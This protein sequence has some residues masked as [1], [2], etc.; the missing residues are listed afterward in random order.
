MP[1]LLRGALAVFDAGFG[2]A[3]YV[4]GKFANAG[5][6]AA[7][8][9]ASWNGS[10][11]ADLGGGVSGTV[12]ALAVFDDGS[13]PELYVG[14]SF[15]A[16][17]GV[18]ANNIAKWNGSTWST[19][20][21]GT[22]GPVYT[23]RVFDDGSGD[24]LYVGGSFSSRI[25]RWDHSGWSTVGGGW[26]PSLASPQS[27]AVFDDGYGTALYVGTNPGC[28]CDA[29]IVKWNGVTWSYVT[30]LV[31]IHSI[32]ALAV[33]EASSESAPGLFVGVQS[34][35]AYH[36]GW[37]SSGI[38]EW[39]GCGHPGVPFCFGDGTSG[40]CPCGNFGAPGHGCEN[41]ASTGGA[42]L[43]SAGW[44][45]L[46]F[47]SLQLT[48]HGERSTAFSI[49]LQ[50]TSSIAPVVYGD[51]LRCISVPLTRLFVKHAVGGIASAPEPGDP[52]ISSRSAA[53]GDPLFVGAT[54]LYQVF[55]R[56]PSTAFCPNP[57]GN[58][59]NISNARRIQWMP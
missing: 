22:D 18:P 45:S 10:T 1:F 41:S 24:A 54:R 11:W 4:G 12:E 34:T 57:P 25:A 51:G 28:E 2:S 50:G 19:V 32:M 38:A 37:P 13:G 17:G 48:C 55:Y 7:N 36:D 40:A 52:S 39:R 30:S 31:T 44:S 46:S 56:D 29:P 6:V 5:S 49:F 21:G 20:G 59:W 58:T 9:I 3:L 16:A 8:N 14:G 15:T 43:D 47:D 27:F 23:L 26:P 53:Q 35:F 33:F 42:I